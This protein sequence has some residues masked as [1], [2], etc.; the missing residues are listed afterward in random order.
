MSGGGPRAPPGIG[1]SRGEI[2]PRGRL[3]WKGAEAGGG[4]AKRRKGGMLGLSGAWRALQNV[5]N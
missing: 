2:M 4:R 3:A 1:A 5:L